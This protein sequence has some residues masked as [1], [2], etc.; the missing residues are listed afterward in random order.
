MPR[1]I[2]AEFP[3][4]RSGQI[5]FNQLV[6]TREDGLS[7]A[8]VK[9][10]PFDPI[11]VAEMPGVMTQDGRRYMIFFGQEDVRLLARWLTDNLP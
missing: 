3:L 2:L 5:L 1:L 4:Q 9:H 8:A 6:T 11:T 7:E 10:G